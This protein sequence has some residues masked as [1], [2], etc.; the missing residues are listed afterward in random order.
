M[1]PLP[2][3]NN[4]EAMAARGRRSALM[5]ARNDA[6]E[7]LRSACVHILNAD[8]LSA[9]DKRFEEMEAAMKRLRELAE[10]WGRE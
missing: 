10:Y 2:D 3:L 8:D 9:V 7:A 1:R 5:S 6:C 4:L